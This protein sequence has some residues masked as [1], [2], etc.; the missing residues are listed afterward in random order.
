MPINSHLIL[1]RDIKGFFIIICP[2]RLGGPYSLLLDGKRGGG[3]FLEER[4]E[5]KSE[6]DLPQVRGTWLSIATT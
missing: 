1:S 3:Q 6:A 2:D 5:F 4:K